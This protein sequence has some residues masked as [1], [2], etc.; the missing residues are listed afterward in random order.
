MKESPPKHFFLYISQVLI[1][2]FSFHPALMILGEFQA[3]MIFIVL[4]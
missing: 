1:E 2:T 4:D 3:Y